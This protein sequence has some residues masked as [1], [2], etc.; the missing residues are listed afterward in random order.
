MYL[1]KFKLSVR[2]LRVLTYVETH[3]RQPH[4]PDVSN[5]KHLMVYILHKHEIVLF[6]YQPDIF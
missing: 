4:N 2:K 3:T 1:A 6:I 5:L